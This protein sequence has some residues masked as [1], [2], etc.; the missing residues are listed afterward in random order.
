MNVEYNN[1][2]KTFAASRKN[3]KWEELE[4]FFSCIEG[5]ENI[6]DIACGS[7]RFL[8]QYRQY[9]WKNPHEYLGLDLS[10]ELLLEAQK[11]FPNQ[12][13]QEWDMQEASKYIKHKNFQHIFCIAGFHHLHTQQERIQTLKDWKKILP[14]WGKIFLTNWAL[15]S[16]LNVNTYQIYRLENKN[17]FLWSSD[18]MIPIGKYERYYHCF[19]LEELLYLAQD[20]GLAVC[21]NRLFET[22]KN[23]ITILQK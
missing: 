22:Q 3:M 15:E 8:E 1:F 12:R 16:P 5:D 11:S 10:A 23:F 13:F 9:F 14:V 20:A 18:Y 4:Y 2:A 19:T 17:A 21:E 6:L 7:G